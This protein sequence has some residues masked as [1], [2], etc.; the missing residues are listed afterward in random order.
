[1]ETYY[2]GCWDERKGHYLKDKNGFSPNPN[3]LPWKQIDGTLAPDTTI[4]AGIA[5][6]HHKDNWTALAFWDYSIDHRPNSNSVFLAKGEFTFDEMMQI[7]KD[8]FPQIME[9]FDFPI[10]EIQMP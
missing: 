5:K 9:R 3:N 7:A 8:D 4:K 6:L 2:L 1:M 10:I